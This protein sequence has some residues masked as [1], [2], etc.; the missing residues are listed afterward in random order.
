M[1]IRVRG[2]A[3]TV[4]ESRQKSLTLKSSPR[5]WERKRE[6]FWRV[7]L[8]LVR[9]EKETAQYKATL[10]GPIFLSSCGPSAV[11][12]RTVRFQI[13]QR[14]TVLQSVWW[15]IQMA[16]GPSTSYTR[17]VRLVTLPPKITLQ[18]L[19]WSVHM[20]CGPSA[21]DKRTVRF[22]T[23]AAQNKLQ[24]LCW[25]NL[26]NRGPSAS[27]PRTVRWTKFQSVQNTAN[28]HNSNFNM[29]SLLI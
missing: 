9:G 29:G 5:A 6:S 13:L 28:F 4:R 15:P 24:C 17:T 23:S 12:R 3:R 26:I 16:R 22:I 27:Y 25:T 21:S 8:G 14:S 7:C 20:T 2:C 10:A 1:L 19:W 11:P 18:S